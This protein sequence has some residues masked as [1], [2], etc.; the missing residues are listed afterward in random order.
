MSRYGYHGKILHVDLRARRAWI[1]EPDERFWR[2]YGGGGL[3]A[4]Y[5]LLR[6][7]PRGVDALD[8]ANLLIVTS[9]VI[10]GHPYASL[11]RFTAAAKSPLT[12]GIGETRCEGP[13]GVALKGSGA[14]ALIVHGAAERA[15][16]IVIEN[17]AVEFYDAQS[18]WGLPV[19]K[20][21][22][23]LEKEIGADVHTAVIGPAGENQVRFASI[24]TERSYQAAR[25]GIGA[26]MGSKRV[27]AIVIRGDH[28]PP[29]ANPARCAELTEHYREAMRDNSVTRW[30]LDPPGFS[31]WIHN[32]GDNNALC[33][34]N[35]R[36]A[37][38]ESAANYAPEKFMPHYRHDGD[39]PGCPNNC[40]KFFED[41]RA[42]GIH[43]EITGAL[44]SNLGIADL[45]AILRANVLCN[46]LGLDPASLGFTLS[47]AM[48]CV[49]RGILDQPLRFGDAEAMLMMIEQIA[50]RKGFGDVLA[51][52]AMR[53]AENVGDDANRYALHVKGLEM[54]CY[55]PRTQTGLGLGYATAPIGPRYEICEHD[56]DFDQVGPPHALDSS[57]TYGI[58]DRI[59]MEELSEKKVRNFKALM[60][61]WSAADALDICPFAIPPV[62]VFTLHDMA[63]MLRAVTGWETSTYELWRFGERRLHL[64][65]VYNLREGLTAADDTLPAR[66]FDEP[67]HKSGRFDGR[68]LDREQFAR[69]VQMY[70]QMIGWD[71]A[72]RPRSETLLDHHL[73][74]TVEE[75][76][77]ERA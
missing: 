35:Y 62:R 76:H 18:L 1:E 13:F 24:V 39:C 50:Q 7:C 9:S 20:T 67:I 73:E 25:M 11:A 45:N 29:V 8:P 31:A 64:M 6:E 23:A 65:R 58:L 49:E 77:A 32:Y 74:W 4:A 41:A 53:A 14:D 36:D 56:M 28:H 46:D 66:F 22:D 54:V 48:E 26:V 63:E 21:V 10:A 2:I 51:E 69:A 34:R 16:T 57:R 33:A 43:Q 47:M 19:S 55:D 61:L 15:T 17:G 5:Y 59:P 72:G 60:L 38:F 12:S 75:G 30:Q 70:Y 68:R 37:D 40:I 27:K 44:G 52:G 42:G 71:D 3:L